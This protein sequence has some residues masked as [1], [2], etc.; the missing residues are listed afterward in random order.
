MERIDAGQGSRVV[1]NRDIPLLARVLYT[2]QDVRSMEERIEWQQDRRRSIA[3]N[4]LTGMP[5]R[6][7]GKPSGFEAALAVI[8]ELNEHHLERLKSYTH[9]LKAAER[10][11]NAIPSRTMRTFVVMFYIEGL[12]ASTVQRELNMTRRGFE[13]ARNAIEQAEDMERVKWSER[14]CAEK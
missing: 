9:E 11:V 4:N 14:F 6:R 13:N 3:Q 1:K 5:G 8:D 10:I 7:G 12:S 2:M